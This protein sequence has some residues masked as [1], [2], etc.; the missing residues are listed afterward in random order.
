MLN[1]HLDIDSEC[2]M[3]D[4]FGYWDSDS[5]R[6]VVYCCAEEVEEMSILIHDMKMPKNCEECP[7]CATIPRAYTTLVYCFLQKGKPTHD[8]CP[9]I[10][11]KTGKWIDKWYCSNMS[12]YE[13]AMKCSECGKPTY[14]ISFA[15]QMPNY[16]P[17]CGARMVQE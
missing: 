14:R 3:D 16:C 17:N 8:D 7:F 4:P 2:D 11:Q 10:E 12:G 15:E 5:D 9:L 6:S 13:Y 1:G